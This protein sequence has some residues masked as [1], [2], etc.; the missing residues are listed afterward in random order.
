MIIFISGSINSGK[1]T[2]AAILERRIPRTAIVEVDAIRKMIEWMPLE[3]SIPINLENA[4]SI[5]RNF[6]KNGLNTV[7]AYPIRK[8]I[9]II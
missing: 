1:S 3:E 9:T 7:I 4:I 5:T 8:K 6:T 2:V